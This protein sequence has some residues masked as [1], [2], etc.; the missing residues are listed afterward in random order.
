MRAMLWAALAPAALLLGGMAPANGISGTWLTEDRDTHVEIAPCGR[1]LCGRVVKFLVAP[2]GGIDQ[3]DTENPDPKLRNR[4]LLGLAVLTGFTRDGD[5]WRGRIY[6]PKSGKSYRS[7]LE[8]N[9]NT[10]VVKGCIGPFCQ[11]QKWRQVR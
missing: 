2:P 8:R 1:S 5:Q 7:V 6:D 11:A 4:R 10:L 9:G 3:R